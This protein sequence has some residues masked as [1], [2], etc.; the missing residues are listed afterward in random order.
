MPFNRYLCSPGLFFSQACYSVLHILKLPTFQLCHIGKPGS[1]E[2]GGIGSPFSLLWFPNPRTA[3]R[4]GGGEA[5]EASIP[6]LLVPLPPPQVSAGQRQ[7]LG[8]WM[9]GNKVSFCL[10]PSP[11]SSLL[12]IF[13][14]F[15]SSLASTTP[16]SVLHLPP[17]LCPLTTH[18][19]SPRTHSHPLRAPHLGV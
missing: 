8:Q 5:Q 10:L 6:F 16:V 18:S 1:E 13:F 15:L 9:E 3:L 12:L 7:A 2:E 14:F 17:E 19:Q 11:L 4:G